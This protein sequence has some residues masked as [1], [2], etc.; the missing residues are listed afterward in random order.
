MSQEA[1]ERLL[2]RLLT[3]DK[4]R[5]IASKSLENACCLGGYQLTT[6]EMKLINTEDFVLIE[7][8]AKRL[9]SKIKRF[10]I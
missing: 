4:F 10:S 6:E 3:D 2:G 1:I 7:L 9:D 8:L 5:N